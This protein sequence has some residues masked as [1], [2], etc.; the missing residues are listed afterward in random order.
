[1]KINKDSGQI[2]IISPYGRVYLYTHN[3]AKSLLT[4]VHNTL[5]LKVRWDD[6]DYLS[7]MLFC[8]M[9]PEQFWSSNTGYGIGTQLYADVELLV[10][11]NTAAQKITLSSGSHEFSN[12]SMGF[13][14]F[15][16][17][18]LKDAKL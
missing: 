11:L 15:I 5:S 17:D 6:P 14:E 13:E 2:E 3:D 4:I 9:I 10:S 8:E 7:R 18:F 12:F 1:M 16:V